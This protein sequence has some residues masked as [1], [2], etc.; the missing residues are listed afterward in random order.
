MG[1]PSKDADAEVL[2]ELQY[3]QENA[4]AGDEVLLAK[5][6]ELAHCQR[7]QTLRPSQSFHTSNNS[8][9][10]DEILSAKSLLERSH[11]QRMHT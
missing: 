6:P 3:H 10:D 9:D 2:S 8:D 5:S 1:R 7:M 4:D 11:C